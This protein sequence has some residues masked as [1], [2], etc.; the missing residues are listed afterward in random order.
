MIQI[1]EAIRLE[2]RS[3]QLIDSIKKI[4]AYEPYLR[5][6]YYPVLKHSIALLLQYS[7]ILNEYYDEIK[8][9]F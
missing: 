4:N 1:D 9:V 3:I 6:K 5:L 7:I 2:N 8:E